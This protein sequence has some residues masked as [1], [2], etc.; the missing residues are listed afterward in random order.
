MGYV[1]Y[2]DDGTYISIEAGPIVIMRFRKSDGQI[3]V[4]EGID[5]DGGF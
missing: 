4:P 3:L 2:S 5:T 1:T